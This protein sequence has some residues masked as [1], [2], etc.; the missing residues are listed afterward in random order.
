MKNSTATPLCLLLFCSSAGVRADDLMENDD[1]GP[2]GDL[3]ELPSP[4]LASTC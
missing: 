4:R 2:G 3:G 1:L